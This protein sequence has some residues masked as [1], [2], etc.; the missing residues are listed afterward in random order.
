MTT[1]TD[2]NHT[3]RNDPAWTK[4]PGRQ[5]T[6]DNGEQY[7]SEYRNPFT[8]QTIR[9]SWRMT[10][11]DWHVFDAAGQLVS[12]EHSLTYA[13]WFAEYALTQASA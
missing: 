13:K 10:G 7:I 11:R 12:R 9:K 8:G 4:T 5:F 1:T 6:A 2:Q 3:H